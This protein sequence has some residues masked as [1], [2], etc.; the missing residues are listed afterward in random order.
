MI[1]AS[2]STTQFR[3][4]GW[5]MFGCMLA[6]F[7]VI[8]AVNVTM[9][10]MASGTWTGLIV[11]NSYV[12]SQKFN[13]ELLKAHAQHARGLRSAIRY[14]GGRLT[15]TIIDGAGGKI[16]PE[17]AT[18]WLGR[19]V[20][21]QEDQLIAAACEFPGTCSVPANL[22]AGN[23]DVSIRAELQEGTYRRDAR[24]YVLANG[25]TQVD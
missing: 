8:I 13:G 3:F 17:N 12:A 9:A 5:H 25:Q 24:I 1:P 4:T 11:K 15:F 16:M 19:P 23:W 14:S 20:F 2:P 6:F 18:V 10:F 22:A 7:G 21:E